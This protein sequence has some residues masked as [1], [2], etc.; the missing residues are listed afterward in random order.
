[1]PNPPSIPSHDNVFGYEENPSG[2][3]V[4]QKN[5]EKVHTGNKADTVGPGEYDIA[6]DLGGDKRGPAW[7][8]PKHNQGKKNEGKTNASISTAVAL[9]TAAETPGPGHYN[10]DKVEIFPIYKYKPSSVFVSKVVRDKH[11]KHH[12]G[13]LPPKP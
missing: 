5:S 3:L 4:R 12:G 11:M 7:H 10:S 13:M 8:A 9:T 2:E 1:M 6:K